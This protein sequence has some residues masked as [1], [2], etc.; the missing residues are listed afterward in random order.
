MKVLFAHDHRFIRDGSLTYT[1]AQFAASTWER[2]LEAFDELLVVARQAPVPAGR[3]SSD[4]ELASREGV[5]FEFL[6]NLSTLGAQLFGRGDARRVM[7]RLVSE[8]DGV[9]AT[10]PTQIGLLA[11]DVAR[12]LG[13][14]YAVLVT[15]CA[16]DGL[17]N[18]GGLKAKAYAPVMLTRVRR[19]VRYAPYVY[20]V[21]REFL[22]NR[23]PNVGGRT[24]A[25]SDVDIAEPDPEVLKAKTRRAGQRAN[26][27]T[28]G[29]I[30]SLQTLNKGVHVVLEALHRRRLDLPAFE[31]RV[32][33]NGDAA[34][35]RERAGRL[36]LSDV[37][38][39]DGTLGAGDP[40]LRWLDRVDVYLQPSFK[41]GLPRALVEAMSR[42]CP[43]IASSC[44]GIPELLDGGALI[45]PGNATR[46]GEL[47]VKAAGDPSWRADQA[48]RNWTRAQEYSRNRLAGMRRD[49]W[50]GFAEHVRSRRAARSGA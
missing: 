5:R 9:L 17:W 11:I 26:K 36:G 27:V 1:E 47:L 7:I 21:T 32:L 34:P 14:P 37:V 28:F 18:Y 41:E 12:S 48:R 3:R 43:A 10:V 29:L 45:R 16:W 39:F 4:F 15:G 24:V 38:H 33:G 20:Y 50:R 8:C 40:V 13:K 42:A 25:C 35:W 46:L 44:G 49:F 23:Y 2:Y 30:G 19:A 22:Q 31:F 6:P